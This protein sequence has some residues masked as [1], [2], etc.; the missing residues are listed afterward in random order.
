MDNDLSEDSWEEAD[1]KSVGQRYPWWEAM[2][3]RVVENC[4]RITIV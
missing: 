4:G 3:D 2:I 1:S